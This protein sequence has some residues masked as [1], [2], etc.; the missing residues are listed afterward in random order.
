MKTRTFV[1]ASLSAAALLAAVQPAQAHEEYRH[2]RHSG[3]A[4]VVVVPP[5]YGVRYRYAPPVVYQPDPPV[6]YQPAPVVY[7]PPA[8]AAPVYVEPAWGAIGGAV[9]GAAVGNQ[10]GYGHNRAAATA[11]GAVIGAIVGDSIASQR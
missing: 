7:G 5:A 1:I 6:V 10:V 8:Y 9:L 11:A 2:W 3:Y 4:R